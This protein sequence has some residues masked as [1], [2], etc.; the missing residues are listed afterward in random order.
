MSKP[1]WEQ[2]ADG[3]FD[4]MEADI[5]ALIDDP[6]KDMMGKYHDAGGCWWLIRRILGRIAALQSHVADLVAER[7]DLEQRIDN[8]ATNFMAAIAK[9]DERIAELQQT[10]LELQE[11]YS[12]S[13]AKCERYE[14]ALETVELK[15]FQLGAIDFG[16]AQELR[17]YINQKLGKCRDR[18]AE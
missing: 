8:Q 13:L 3:E 7:S 9:R 5:D 16:T 17:H 15:L 2:N 6:R 10:A 12:E 18:E 11:R 14:K 4:N 1:H